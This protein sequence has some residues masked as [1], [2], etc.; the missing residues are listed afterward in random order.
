MPNR[1][2]YKLYM[3]YRDVNGYLVL[4]LHSRAPFRTVAFTKC[5]TTGI[6][7]IVKRYG[8]TRPQGIIWFIFASVTMSTNVH[9]T[10][11]GYVL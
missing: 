2:A 6:V 10:T 4:G 7:S 8:Y 11:V 3:K 5:G 1:T 9:T